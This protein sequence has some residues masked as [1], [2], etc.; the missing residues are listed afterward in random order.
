MYINLG[1]L[2]CKRVRELVFM[3]MRQLADCMQYL[4]VL[5]TLIVSELVV[6]CHRPKMSVSVSIAVSVL[7]L[8]LTPPF[9]SVVYSR[10]SVAGMGHV[11]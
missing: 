9:S 3:F 6:P 11:L 10:P 8:Y 5:C 7:R 2:N 4:C 1:M